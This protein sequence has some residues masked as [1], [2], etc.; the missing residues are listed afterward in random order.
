[1]LIILTLIGNGIILLIYISF[2]AAIIIYLKR[3]YIKKSILR[4]LSQRR[5]IRNLEYYFLTDLNKSKDRRERISNVN[6]LTNIS[7]TG[8]ILGIL[9][10]AA[11]ATISNFVFG[12]SSIISIFYTI[13]LLLI[14][15][16]FLWVVCVIFAFNYPTIFYCCIPLIS[17]VIFSIFDFEI[18]DKPDYL[19]LLIFLFIVA[20]IGITFSLAL[21]VHVIRKVNSKVVTFTALLTVITTL[22]IQSTSVM[23]EM[24]LKNENIILTAKIVENDPS[25]S[26]ELKKFLINDDV[27]NLINHFI[28]N[29]M[30][31]EFNGFFSFIVSGI[32][33]SFIIGGIFISLRI[34]RAKTIS[35]KIFYEEILKDNAAS[36]TDLVKCAYLGGDEYELIILNNKEWVEIIKQHESVYIRQ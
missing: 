10:S 18:Y 30:T 28:I 1:M 16:L 19:K 13:A 2:I 32:T 21:P 5:K 9:L 7:F 11:I 36:Y 15:F 12:K 31:S 20:I 25:L 24:L 4:L 33:L 17:L 29:E 26:N 23:T 6:L 3:K 14:V 35:K 22:F 8:Y 34:S 27:L